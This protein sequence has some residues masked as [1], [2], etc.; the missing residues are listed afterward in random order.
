MSAHD[1]S[2]ALRELVERL[3]GEGRGGPPG[4]G[5]T[6]QLLVG[7]LPP[8]L[9][10]A[11]PLPPGSRI[12]GTAA[13]QIEDPFGGMMP[14]GGRTRRTWEIAFDAP[15]PAAEVGTFY[16]QALIGQ[17]WTMPREGPQ[18]GI[19]G[20]FSADFEALRRAHPPP[21]MAAQ[22]AAFERVRP[23]HRTFCPPAGTGGSLRLTLTPRRDGSAQVL[24]HLDD[25]PF[26]PCGMQEMLEATVA[27]RLPRLI[28][29]PEVALMPGGGGGSESRWTSEA[30]ATTDQ[31]VGTLEAHFAAQLAAAGWVRRAGEA[32]E[33][34]AW[35]AWTV[36]GEP[37]A[38]GFLSVRQA[39]G[40]DQRECVVLIES[41]D[42]AFG[43]HGG[44]S[45]VVGKS[46][47]HRLNQST[48]VPPPTEGGL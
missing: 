48:A 18:M 14:R 33:L 29:P 47:A 5:H 10:I 40:Q 21:E 15:L 31:P 26:G 19:E 43:T 7:M 22:M 46:F 4:E 25:H 27:A 39:A 2:A 38:E 11:L 42:S 41:E 37:A 1:E 17:G 32:A 45:F 30:S 6:V 20:G 34:L 9:P 28:P 3:L 24:G 36:P 23:E 12:I 44:G 35:S 16:E 8:D 13:H